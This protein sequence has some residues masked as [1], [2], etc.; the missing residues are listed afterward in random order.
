MHAE[1]AGSPS[2]SP[3]EFPS[4]IYEARLSRRASSFLGIS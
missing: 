4:G 3:L 2:N 1:E